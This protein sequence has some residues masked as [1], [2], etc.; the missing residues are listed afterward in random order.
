MLRIHQQLYHYSFNYL[1]IGRSDLLYTATKCIQ[2][3]YR[4]QMIGKIRDYHVYQLK[5][6][7]AS[8]AFEIIYEDER[9]YYYL[10][11]SE[12]LT[13]RFVSDYEVFTLKEILSS[14]KIT[15]QDLRLIPFMIYK[16]SK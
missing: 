6:I 9:D 7:D 12:S 3:D 15:I 8:N 2:S 16:L 11:S 5:G 14:G 4:Y 1:S 10:L 13:I